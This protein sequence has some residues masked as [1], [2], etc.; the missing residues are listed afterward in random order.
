MSRNR[1]CVGAR[2]AHSSLNNSRANVVGVERNEVGRRLADAEELDRHIDRL[3]HRDD[4]A[5]ARRAV[6]LRHDEP[7][8]RNRGG[9]DLRLLHGVLSD[10]SVEHEQRLVRRAGQPL[11]DDAR[12]FLELVH[13]AFA[14]VQS[15]GGVDDQHVDAARDRGVDRVERDGAGIGSRLRAD[16]LGAR[17]LRPDAQ[18]IDRAGAK[19]V[20]R[21]DHHALLLGAKARG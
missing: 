18:L 20:A 21:R 9:E 17:A 11:R 8:H 1:R 5:A 7:G 14:R 10:R 16:E 12:D 15:T 6:E 19:R 13:Q 4:D 2:V 3:V